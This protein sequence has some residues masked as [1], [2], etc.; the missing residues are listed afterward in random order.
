MTD[1]TDRLRGAVSN[2]GNDGQLLEDAVDE[3]ERLTAENTALEVRV[4]SF[5]CERSSEIERLNAE[6]DTLRTAIQQ[7]L[8]E[9]GHLADG[10]VC[11]LKILKDA[12]LTGETP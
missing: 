8:A 6:R 12:L 11:T 5:L 3:I 2:D 1:L 7:T 10:D 4:G 9:N